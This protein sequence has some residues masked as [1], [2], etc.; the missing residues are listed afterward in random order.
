MNDR[1]T[2]PDFIAI[3]NG[4]RGEQRVRA[5]KIL[6]KEGRRLQAVRGIKGKFDHYPLAAWIKIRI[7]HQG[8]TENKI[9]WDWEVLQR[10]IRK[11][12]P[13]GEEMREN[14]GKRLDGEGMERMRKGKRGRKER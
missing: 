4:W 3:P 8:M 2:R 14:V 12:E 5:C 10:V 11:G 1:A 9:R 7:E 6:E 13:K